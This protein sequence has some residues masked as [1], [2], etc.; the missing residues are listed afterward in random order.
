MLPRTK[1]A[2]KLIEKGYTPYR[3]AK[4]AGVSQSTVHRA[5]ARLHAPTC[6]AC[7]QKVKWES[8][9]VGDPVD[10]KL[11]RSKSGHKMAATKLK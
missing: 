5:L 8:T 2:L 9:I 3:A 10:D 4:D 7:G 6:P 11:M 1:Q